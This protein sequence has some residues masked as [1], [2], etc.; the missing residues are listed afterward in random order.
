MLIALFVFV[1]S[2]GMLVLILLAVVVA[3]IRR[4]PSAELGSRP[5]GLISALVR[6]VLGV[7]VRRPGPP[8]GDA[9]PRDTC[10]TGHGMDGERR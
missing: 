5:P 10:L 2:I 8:A 3:G 4:E 1:L 7:G 6:R 9:S